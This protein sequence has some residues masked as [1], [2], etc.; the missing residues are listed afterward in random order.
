MLHN[1]PV[2]GFHEQFWIIIFIGEES[3][4]REANTFAFAFY[5][6][7][8]NCDYRFS[9]ARSHDNECLISKVIDSGNR[10]SVTAESSLS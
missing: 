3:I 7:I 5:F 1:P 9:E 6:F 10:D 2:S 8:A 4:K